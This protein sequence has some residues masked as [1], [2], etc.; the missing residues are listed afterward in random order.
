MSP[1]V[2]VTYKTMHNH[3]RVLFILRKGEGGTLYVEVRSMQRTGTFMVPETSMRTLDQ[4][5]L[6]VL[7]HQYLDGRL[8]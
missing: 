3:D 2:D 1:K 8:S 4:H 6:R 7:V 5:E